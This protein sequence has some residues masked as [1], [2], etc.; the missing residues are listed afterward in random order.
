MAGAAADVARETSPAGSRSPIRVTG[1]GHALYSAAVAGLGVLLVSGV[2]VYVWAPLPRWLPGRD[3]VAG[4]AGAVMLIAAIGL[5]GRTTVAVASLAL[6]VLFAAW[7]LLLQALHLIATPS[8]ELL[9]SG[10]GQ[11]ATIIAGGW[12]L[13]ACAPSATAAPGRRRWVTAAR[14]LYAV[15]LVPI[16]LHH[17]ADVAQA[18]GAVPAWL[19]ARPLWVEATGVAHIAAGA[20]ILLRLV[21]RLAATLE[22]AMISGFVLL[23]HVPGVI[24]AP[25][26]ALQWTM[27]IVASAIVGAAWIVAHSYAGAAA[28]A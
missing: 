5:L 21:P 17:F 4:A 3:L 25:R 10:A 28:R 22:A 12:I 8:A 13:F 19:P 26:D 27:L 18:A 16:G 15:A 24:G 14:A 1:P 9:W 20:A 23:V 7:L 6:S 2:F 11:L